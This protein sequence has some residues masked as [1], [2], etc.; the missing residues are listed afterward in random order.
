MGH[1]KSEWRVLLHIVI[2]KILR[3]QFR[4]CIDSIYIVFTFKYVLLY[5]CHHSLGFLKGEEFLDYWSSHN[6][7]RKKRSPWSLLVNH[8]FKLFVQKTQTNSYYQFYA[9][10]NVYNGCVV[11]HMMREGSHGLC[12]CVTELHELCGR[13]NWF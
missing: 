11:F 4:W 2:S 8:G 7:V 9:V 3:R 6:R 13:W 12:G 10:Q 5:V 1:G